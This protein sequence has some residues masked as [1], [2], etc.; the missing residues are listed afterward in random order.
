M[1]TGNLLRKLMEYDKEKLAEEILNKSLKD[2]EKAKLPCAAA[3]LI[4]KQYG[5]S[6]SVIGSICN[7]HKIKITRCQL[8]CF[9]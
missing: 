8:G 5:V 3:F 6:L 7:E 4:A 1:N 2:G 9:K